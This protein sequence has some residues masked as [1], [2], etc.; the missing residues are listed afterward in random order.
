LGYWTR[1]PGKP[2]LARWRTIRLATRRRR[3]RMAGAHARARTGIGAAVGVGILGTEAS[4][5]AKLAT[6]AEAI[7]PA[8]SKPAVSR[9][10][11]P[12]ANPRARAGAVEM[13]GATAMI[14]VIGVEAIN[15]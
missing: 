4:G 13:I 3:S 12:G 6:E 15:L 11:A 2:I 9:E 14:V 10:R 1:A 8:V 5:P 7:K